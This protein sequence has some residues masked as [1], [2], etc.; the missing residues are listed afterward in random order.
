MEI[1]FGL[2]CEV[3]GYKQST[4]S[5]RSLYYFGMQ[6]FSGV[7][8]AACDGHGAS[9]GPHHGEGPSIHSATADTLSAGKNA[10][11]PGRFKKL[12]LRPPTSQAIQPLLAL[13]LT[14]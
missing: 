2:Q 12:S 8:W 5:H 13:G 9:L 11:S 7:L 3:V 14:L 4:A 1:R 10:L 6:L